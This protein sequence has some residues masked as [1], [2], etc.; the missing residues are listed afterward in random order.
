MTPMYVVFGAVAALAALSIAL[1]VADWF[2][3]HSLS[4]RL[5]SI[6]QEV[7]KKNLEFDALRKE[8]GNSAQQPY[9]AGSL[10]GAAD[11]PGEATSE[12]QVVRNV[13]DGYDDASGSP[14]TGSHLEGTIVEM[15]AQSHYAPAPQAHIMPQ[16]YAPPTPA[17]APVQAA[18]QQNPAPE[19]PAVEPYGYQPQSYAPAPEPAMPAAQEPPAAAPADAGDVMDVVGEG[20]NEPAPPDDIIRIAVYSDEKKDADF[21]KVS[22]ILKTEFPLHQS[23]SVILDFSQVTFIYEKEVE[24]LTRLTTYASGRRMPLLFVNCDRELLAAISRYP[25]L[26]ACVRG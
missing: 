18:F 2:I 6:D 21:Q 13:R 25:S 3:L 20:G 11:D 8:R 1:A 9:L 19:T 23:P 4:N 24:Y 22:Q 12:I 15:G 14:P 10:G 5:A 26:H 7:E 16:Q 17:H